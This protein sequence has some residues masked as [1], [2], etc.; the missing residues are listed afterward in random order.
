MR[1]YRLRRA[2]VFDAKYQGDLKADILKA[3]KSEKGK[4]ALN[5]LLNKKECAANIKEWFKVSAKSG[6]ISDLGIEKFLD[7]NYKSIISMY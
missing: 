3:L 4:A 1:R 6:V 7:E 5:K 2:G